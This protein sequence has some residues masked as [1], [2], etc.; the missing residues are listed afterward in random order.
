MM[1]PRSRHGSVEP[2]STHNTHKPKTPRPS[3]KKKPTKKVPAVVEQG[4]ELNLDGIIKL[5]D[6]AAGNILAVSHAVRIH[7]DH[8]NAVEQKAVEMIHRVAKHEG[9]TP[10][11]LIAR[12]LPKAA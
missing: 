11:K 3:M 10:S 4:K 7:R 6:E 2:L 9:V 8:L 1:L 12:V 5:L